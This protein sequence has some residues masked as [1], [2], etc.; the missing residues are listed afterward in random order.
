[1][2]LN[3][4][5][6]S[7]D[8]FYFPR[9]SAHLKYIPELESFNFDVISAI[10]MDSFHRELNKRIELGKYDYIFLDGFL[11]FEDDKLVSMIDK[12][13]FL[14]LTKEECLSRRV[15]RNYKTVDTPNYFD[16]CVWVEFLRYKHLVET[17]RTNVVYVDG[18]QSI[19]EIFRLTLADMT[20]LDTQST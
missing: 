11:L 6:M 17:K 10:D 2:F 4:S 13:Y 19:D 5:Y 18:S 16:K 14:Y 8:D 15:S 7:Q 20:S 1:M 12:K 9:D 3:S